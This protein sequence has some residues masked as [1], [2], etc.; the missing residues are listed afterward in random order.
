MAYLDY[1]GLVRYNNKVN[2]K[3]ALKADAAVLDKRTNSLQ[4]QIDNITEAEDLLTTIEY[5]DGTYGRGTVPANKSRYAEAGTIKGKTRAW[6]QLVPNASTSYTSI[7][8]DTRASLQLTARTAGSVFM[9]VT[10][11]VT[12]VYSTIFTATDGGT[13]T[14]K[15]NGTQTDLVF[16]TADVVADHKYLLTMNFTGVDVQTVGGLSYDHALLRDLTLI[17]GAGNEPSTVADALALISA[18]GE[19]DEYNA[20]S[21]VDTVVSGIESVGVNLWDEQWE[22]GEYSGTG[23]KASGDGIRSAGFIELQPSVSYYLKNS[24]TM[25]LCFYDENKT[26]IRRTSTGGNSVINQNIN[27]RYLTFNTASAYGNVYKNDIQ[28]CLDSYADKTTYHPYSKHTLTLPTPV[29]LR[30]AGSVAETLDVETG[31]VT[32]PIGSVDLGTLNWNYEQV[33]VGYN[34]TSATI[35]NILSRPDSNNTIANGSC[36]MYAMTDALS[37]YTIDK[38]MSIGWDVNGKI[39]LR[40]TSK[41]GSDIVDGHASFLDGIILYYELATPAPSTNIGATLD[42][43]IEVEGGGT[44]NTVQTQTPEIDSCLIATYVNKVT[45]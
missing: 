3:L 22:V 26:F 19:Y 43:F 8:M 6:N 40:N 34:F 15:H 39:R 23:Q 37:L 44:I 20:G 12:G 17:F 1:D 35:A 29:T 21:L 32:H 33:S 36:A 25:W 27:E 13:C 10:V 30:S 18:L 31:E 14:V 41:S 5:P 11:T 45:A 9:Q 24:A 4:K 28:I 38:G 42:N 16:F 7:A 2:S